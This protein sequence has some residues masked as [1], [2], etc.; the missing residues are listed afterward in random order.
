MR[1]PEQAAQPAEG[2]HIALGD[3]ALMGEAA[4]NRMIY[5]RKPHPNFLGM[6]FD[7]QALPSISILLPVPQDA[8]EFIYRDVYTLDGDQTKPGN[9]VKIM[10]NSSMKLWQA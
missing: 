5:S 10:K 3:E 4:G 1:L 9:A 8:L 7:E 2:V 6:G